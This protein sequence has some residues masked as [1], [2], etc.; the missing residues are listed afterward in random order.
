MLSVGCFFFK[1]KAKVKLQ[2]ESQRDFD[3]LAIR[4]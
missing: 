2:I 1:R 4:I 3:D